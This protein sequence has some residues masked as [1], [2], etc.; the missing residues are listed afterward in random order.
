VITALVGVMLVQNLVKR[1]RRKF[2]DAFPEALDSIVRS[3]RAGYPL[4]SAIR[5]I[6][7]DL[8]APVG[9]EFK[10]VADETAY[11]WTL[12]EALA[13]MAERVDEPD[14][15]FFSVVLTVQ[16][17]SGGN[18]SEVLSNLSNVIRKR[19]Q[20][21]LKIRALTA[22]GRATSWILGT[23]PVFAFVVIIFSV[24]EHV[25]PLFDSLTGNLILGA[26][27]G[28]VIMGMTVVHRIINMEV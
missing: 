24:P 19:K 28:M 6:G 14:V 4:N 20:L 22:E 23:L 7:D 25:Q 21:R 17:E 27:F 15:R 10:R 1:N 16:Q 13:R 11:G 3:V 8:P 12:Y 2:L 18:L 9:P 26:A 5:L